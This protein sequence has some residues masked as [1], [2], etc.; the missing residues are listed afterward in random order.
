[1]EAEKL[2]FR[3][4]ASMGLGLVVIVVLLYVFVV[5][6]LIAFLAGFTIVACGTIYAFVRA[7]GD[8]NGNDQADSR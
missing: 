4:G 3:A 2:F 6:I 1:M 5:P 8:R 7:S